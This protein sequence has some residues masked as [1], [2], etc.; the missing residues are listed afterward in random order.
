MEAGKKF[1]GT[2][3]KVMKN[4]FFRKTM[5]KVKDLVNLDS[6]ARPEIEKINFGHSLH[7][8]DGILETN[9]LF[10]IFEF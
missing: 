1:Q 6:I 4:D 3:Y 5:E 9:Q 7:G 10:R 8:F 2:L